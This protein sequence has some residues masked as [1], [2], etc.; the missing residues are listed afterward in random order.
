VYEA[1]TKREEGKPEW[2]MGNVHVSRIILH[3]KEK[4]FDRG[5]FCPLSSP[6]KVDFHLS[7]VTH[8]GLPCPFSSL[9]DWYGI[10]GNLTPM[11]PV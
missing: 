4:G 6:P 7:Q 11:M 8:P 1:Q 10:H 9:Y 3:H 5:G 2:M